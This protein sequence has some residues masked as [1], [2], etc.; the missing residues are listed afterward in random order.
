MAP[1]TRENV[2]STL[3]LV[4]GCGILIY[5]LLF[6]TVGLVPGGA[7]VLFGFRTLLSAT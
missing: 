5:W 2:I 1:W 3:E 4:T 6:F 7:R